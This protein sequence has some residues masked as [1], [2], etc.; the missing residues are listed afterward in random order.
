[1]VVDVVDLYRVPFERLPPGYTK[2]GPRE[3]SIYKAKLLERYLE[4]RDTP[5]ERAKT[6]LEYAEEII[7]PS[8]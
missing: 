3:F 1:M 2:I 8:N 6:L 5:P 7:S 4:S